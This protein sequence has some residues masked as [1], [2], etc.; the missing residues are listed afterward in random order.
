MPSKTDSVLSELR[1]QKP[2]DEV[3]EDILER[4]WKILAQSGTAQGL[5]FEVLVGD[6]AN[7]SK[8]LQRSEFA[9]DNCVS[10][11]S[12]NLVVAN[13]CFLTEMEGAVRAFE[14]TEALEACPYLRSDEDLFGLIDAV[15]RDPHKFVRRSRQLTAGVTD[16][17]DAVR[18][19]IA[20]TFVFFI[21]HEL[22]HLINKNNAQNFT[23]FVDTREAL[24]HRLANAVVK[25]RRHAEEFDSFGFDL[26][27]FERVHAKGD[28]IERSSA[29]LR[30]Q[31]ERLELNH[32]VWFER[33]NKADEVGTRVVL[34]YLD[35]LGDDAAANTAMY[36]AS[37]GVFAAAMF[38]WYRD[39]RAFCRAL[40]IGDLPNSQ[41]FT[42]AMT[43]NRER[44]IQAASLFGEVHRFTLLRAERFVQAMIKARSNALG[45]GPGPASLK[46]ASDPGSDTTLWEAVSRYY[47]LCIM[48]DTAVK[49]ANFGS[50]TAWVLETDRKRGTNQV[51]MM[52]FE[53]ITAAMA[54]LRGYLNRS[55]EG[56]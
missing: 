43:H 8:A 33:E 30:K 7:A 54:R 46:G 10:L 45:P 9:T 13:E 19:A 22:G 26:P 44:Y 34:E 51:F 47:L 28:D 56:Q 37:R 35:S 6:F 38:S 31:L 27:G 18:D 39:L 49:I 40:A 24:E 53:T 3:V 16:K 20:L 42:L 52:T 15:G 21:G 12:Q 48:M 17:E 2:R 23:E 29:D 41:A 1:A 11:L 50:A 4:V 5:E 32:S 14:T 25:L 36:R 55:Q